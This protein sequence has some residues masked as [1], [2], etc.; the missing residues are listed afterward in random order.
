MIEQYYSYVPS[1]VAEIHFTY[2]Q[3]RIITYSAAVVLNKLLSI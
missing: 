1:A 2:K 3:T